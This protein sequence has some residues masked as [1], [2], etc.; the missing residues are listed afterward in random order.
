MH[1][2]I[3]LKTPSKTDGIAQGVAGWGDNTLMLVVLQVAVGGGSDEF[4]YY[5]N[6][7]PTQSD[8][9]NISPKRIRQSH[10]EYDTRSS[11]L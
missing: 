11:A 5:G 8:G 4:R 9:M 7:S 6:Y 10:R 2:T 1:D 3:L